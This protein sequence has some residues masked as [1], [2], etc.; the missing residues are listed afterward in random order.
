MSYNN[1]QPKK[2]SVELIGWQKDAFKML[3]ENGDGNI[4]VVKSARQ[5]GKSYFIIISMLDCAINHKQST[6]IYVAPTLNQ[7]R[8][9]FKDIL[10]MLGTIPVVESSNGSLLEIT[11]KN[12]SQILFKSQEQK[13]GLRGY[14]VKGGGALFIDEGTFVTDETYNMVLPYVS[15]S[16]ANVVICSTPL[17]KSGNFY[18]FYVKG[19]NHENNFHS[20]DVM[21]YDNSY[22]IS[23]EQ[24]QQF[25]ESMT[26]MMFKSEIL[27]EFVDEFSSTFGDFKSV[28]TNEFEYA[29]PYYMGVD[30]GVGSGG[31]Y[32]S[33]VVMNSKKQ[34]CDLQYFNDCDTETTIER[35]IKMAEKWNV[36]V[37]TTEINSIGHVYFDLLDK[38]MGGRFGLT[39][40]VTDNT[41]KNR[42]IN[43]LTLG[44]EKQEVTLLDDI[45]LKIQFSNYE[46]EKTKT[47]KIT[48]NAKSGYHDDI[49]MSTAICL[50]SIIRRS[51]VKKLYFI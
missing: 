20:L 34:M 16:K 3:K 12:G 2:I 5:R 38:R 50:D 10:S 15:V 19:L 36:R 39:K 48:Y 17:F 13:E 33:L 31:D 30:F 29:T 22:F 42:I 4:F 47:N 41:S 21:A 32:T 8:K 40:F 37:T 1:P 26:T 23:E 51:D 11:F 24:Q 27:G 18:N 35:I 45:Q 25:F 43:E 6:T 28:C 44:I 9:A 7:C 49:V 46:C 14:T